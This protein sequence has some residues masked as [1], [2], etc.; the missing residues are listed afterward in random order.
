[1]HACPDV[2]GAEC[3]GGGR[4]GNTSATSPM[5]SHPI[6]VPDR[7]VAAGHRAKALKLQQVERHQPKV[8]RSAVLGGEAL[9]AVLP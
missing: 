6:P 7:R 2:R 5:L 8:R 4:A 9:L 1:M 3:H